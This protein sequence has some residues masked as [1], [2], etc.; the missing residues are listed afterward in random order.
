[1]RLESF[2]LELLYHH[3]CVVVPQW[4]GLVANYRPARLN[5][6]THVIAPPSKHIGFNKNLITDDGLLAHHMGLVL[7]ITHAD[8]SELIAREVAA[9]KALMQS[10]GRVIWE[11][12]GVFYSDIQGS[13]Q[14]MPQD[15]ENFLLSSFGL[16]PIQLKALERSQSPEATPVISL[17]P[18]GN[19]LWNWKYASAALLPMIVAGGLW[20]ASHQNPSGGMNW[21]SLNPFRSN[22]VSSA[23]VPRV[24]NDTWHYEAPVNDTPLQ[25]GIPLPTV[26]EEA[27]P[28]AKPAVTA[29]P[30]KALSGYAVIGGAFKVKDN[31]DHFLAQLKSEGFEARMVG[32]SSAIHLVAYGVYAS[33]QEAANAAANVRAAGGK[34]AWIKT[35]PNAR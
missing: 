26:M 11:K 6:V 33:R 25:I 28:A 17:Q 34:S 15:Q 29:A 23:Y 27:A 18:A 10:N 19:R 31:A 2:V 5:A 30:K 4:G 21:A 1:M 9:T 8:A 32:K 24:I 22:A 3:D 13:L 14:F 16:Y 12:I 20:W 35:L 7:G